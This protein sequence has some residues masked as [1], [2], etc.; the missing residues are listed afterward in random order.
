[1]IKVMVVGAAGRMGSKVCEAVT[2]AEGM[3]LAAVIDSAYEGGGA[4]SDIA[5]TGVD[6]YPSVAAC[7][8]EGSCEVA[9]DFT[10]PAAVF[11]NVKACLK[12]GVHCVVGTTGLDS[13]QLEE[14]EKLAD[15]GEANCFL[16]PN[17]A[18]GA[19]LLMEAARAISKHMSSCEIIEQHH[20]QKLDAP[21]GTALRTADLIAEARDGN[22]PD[23]AGPEG[24]PARGII[25]RGI[26]IHSVRLPG[27]VAHQ[28]VIF[29][30]RGQTL[31][32]RHDSISRESFMPGVIL[33]IRSVSELDGLVVGLEKIL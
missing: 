3:T 1:M 27:L 2:A 28:E 10:T 26:P 18:I 7:L 23:P 30:G 19:V 31:T 20:D 25:R 16:A 12:Q 6:R 5:P 15:E 29:G 8:T 17:F 33:A 9:V 11:S 21:S 13:S 4:A 14:L 22:Q 32:L 24:S